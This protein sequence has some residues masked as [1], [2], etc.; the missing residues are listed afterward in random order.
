MGSSRNNKS[1]NIAANRPAHELASTHHAVAQPQCDHTHMQDL[2]LNLH[3]C[4]RMSYNRGQVAD[5]S[6]FGNIY[7]SLFT[8][9]GS[10]TTNKLQT[11]HYEK[12]KGK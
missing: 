2:R 9:V 11:Q 7:T 4:A 8:K 10:N 1:C 12:Q 6:R 3:K 5:L